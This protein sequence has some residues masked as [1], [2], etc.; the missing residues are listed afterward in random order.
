MWRVCLRAPSLG[1]SPHRTEII[2]L[3]PSLVFRRGSAIFV[4]LRGTFVPSL[5]YKS[6][7]W[8]STAWGLAS[9]IGLRLENLQFF[10][11]RD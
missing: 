5:T 10:G 2:T 4:P 7:G 9:E 6:W 3:F 1:S 8:R 11:L